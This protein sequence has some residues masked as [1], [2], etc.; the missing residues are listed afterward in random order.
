MPNHIWGDK[1]F[2]KYGDDLNDAINFI[3]EYVDKNGDG[4]FL[5]CKEKYGTIRY[6]HT[7][8]KDWRTNKLPWDTIESWKVV[9]E[10][11]KKATEKWPNIKKELVTRSC[12]TSIN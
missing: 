6:E 11:T 10:A 5:M 4:Y 7:I 12:K 1:W 8:P 2:Q 9:A 3:V